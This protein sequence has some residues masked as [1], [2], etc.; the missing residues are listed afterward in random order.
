MGVSCDRALEALSERGRRLTHECLM[1]E[2]E[3]PG[4]KLPTWYRVPGLTLS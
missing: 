2:Q 4:E 3:G 1:M